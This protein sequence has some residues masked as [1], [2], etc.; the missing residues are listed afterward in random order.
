MNCALYRITVQSLGIYST[1]HEQLVSSVGE[2]V[3]RG[4]WRFPLKMVLRSIVPLMRSRVPLKM[5][6]SGGL[7]MGLGVSVCV[8]S[9]H[10]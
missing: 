5:V 9:Y 6:L 10:F 7:D 1:A 8:S 2:V 4:N 3:E